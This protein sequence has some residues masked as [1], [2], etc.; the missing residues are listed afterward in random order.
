M[1]PHKNLDKTGVSLSLLC[2]VHCLAGPLLITA[3]PFLHASSYEVYFHSL[4]APILIGIA[5]FAFYRG[6]Q[7]HANPRILL[8]AFLGSALLLLA[9]AFPNQ[10]VHSIFTIGTLMSITGSTVLI[11]AHLWNIRS[12]VCSHH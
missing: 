9:L 4:F 7:K 2:L 12:C 3:F 11:V 1:E 5:F 8:L 10:E 6:Y